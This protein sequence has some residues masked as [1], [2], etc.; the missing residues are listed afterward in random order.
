MTI[1]LIKESSEET[2]FTVECPTGNDY[3]VTEKKRT[4]VFQ[5][6]NGETFE[7]IHWT[8][9]A[10]TQWSDVAS[11]TLRPVRFGKKGLYFMPNMGLGGEHDDTSDADYFMVKGAVCERIAELAYNY[12]VMAQDGMA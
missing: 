11:A 3:I 5:H 6:A 9:T 7:V 1:E 12:Q 2:I 4:E 8:W 10:D